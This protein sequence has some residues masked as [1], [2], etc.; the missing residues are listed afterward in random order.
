MRRPDCER[1]AALCCV[2]TSFDACEDFAIDKPAGEACRHLQPDRR[3][4][5]HAELRTRGF[6]GC[7]IYDCYGAGP[8]VTRM[9]EGRPEAQRE[10]HEAF[11]RLRVLHERMWLVSEAHALCRAAY[12]ELAARLAQALA[13]LETCAA[14]T[15]SGERERAAWDTANALL[16]EVGRALGGRAGVARSLPVVR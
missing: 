8:R 14:A 13:A 1:C 7:A 11:L 3:C 15:P 2:A 16:L 5:I 4:S 10:R 12:P 9:F 6:S